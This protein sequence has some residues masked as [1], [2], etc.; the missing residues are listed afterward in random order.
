MQKLA[1]FVP[2]GGAALL[3]LLVAADGPTPLRLALAVAVCTFGVG[4]PIVGL[5][6]LPPSAARAALVCGTSLAVSVVVAQ[7]LVLAGRLTATVGAT[8]LLV[9]VGATTGSLVVRAP[10]LTAPAPPAAVDDGSK[11]AGPAVAWWLTGLAAALWAVAA[12][13]FEPRAA[14]ELGVVS[15]LPAAWWL[16][17][18]VLVV[19]IGLHAR[20]GIAGGLAVVQ[21]AALVGYLYATTAVSQPFSRIPTT[22]TH[23]GLVDYIVRDHG[24]TSFFDGRYSWP[25]SLA[26]GALLT[27]LA[28]AVT[29]AEIVRWAIPAFV[30]LWA[31]GVHAVAAAYSDS[32][33][34]RWLATWTFLALN[35]VSQDYWSSQALNFLLFVVTVAA[36][37]TWFPRRE[38]GPRTPALLPAAPAP[39]APD[40]PETD[41]R[42]P[43]PRVTTTPGQRVGLFLLLGLIAAA[44][45]SS[46]QLSPFMVTGALVVLW[47]LDRRDIQLLPIV[48]ATVT[49]VWLSWGAQAYWVSHLSR[50]TADVGDV[51]SVVSSG[52][53]GRVADRAAAGRRVVLA[54]RVALSGLAWVAAALAVLR[55]RHRPGVVAVGALVV[56][57]FG[58]ITMQ[59][60]GGELFLRIFLFSLPFIALGLA[61][62]VDS[63]LR[64]QW[65]RPTAAG[66]LAVAGCAVVLVGFVVARHGNE[67]FEQIY[68]ED[69]AAT[70]FFYDVAP[71]GT[72]AVGTNTSNP[73]RM[74][75][76]NDYEPRR[77]A[78]LSQPDAFDV[79]DSLR[80]TGFDH[81]FVMIYESA[82]HEAELR[83]GSPPGWHLELRQG[84]ERMGADLRF[85]DRRAAVYEY[86]LEDVEPVPAADKA[87]RTRARES[88]RR[89]LGHPALALA[90]AGLLFVT[91]LGAFRLG[92]WREARSWRAGAEVSAG[93]VVAFVAVLLVAR[94]SAFT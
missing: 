76:Y 83:F 89:A 67:R 53:A 6:D 70:R 26:V 41:P 85:E 80:L 22:Y 59:Q 30:C 49:L 52:T 81:G 40:A 47:L 74:G 82:I 84:L 19:A 23:V 9:V 35:W 39:D 7:V 62:V 50:L 31:L 18:M 68:R 37:A 69:V 56:M 77:V 33:R 42:G 73:F 43:E 38:R 63:A 91:V 2:A 24:I 66:A 44:V 65:R 46:H 36:V 16:G 12:V 90:L 21:T 4:A 48:A 79:E 71:A 27:Q 10:R 88:V 15:A 34:V 54:V 5:L 57:P 13:V 94:F 8:V 72:H 51:G 25:G 55:L 32:P 45:A 75:P 92:G 3:W 11:S 20:R 60:Y 86:T 1:R 78:Q 17:A 64:R 93:L 87:P 58:A 28:G 14:G 61:L 29:A